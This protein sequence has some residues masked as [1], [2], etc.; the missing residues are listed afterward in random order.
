[1]THPSSSKLSKQKRTETTKFSASEQ[2]VN[3][4]DLTMSKE[5]PTLPTISENA[6]VTRPSPQITAEH[7]ELDS[8]PLW[9]K[10]EEGWQLTWPIWHMLPRDERKEL[11]N[12]HGYKTIGEFEE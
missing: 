1:M 9:R 5:G 2:S 7:E 11:A 6:A 3:L 10:Q 8:S 12:K 4:Y